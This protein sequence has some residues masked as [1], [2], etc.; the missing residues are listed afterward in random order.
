MAHPYFYH[1]LP[2]H[3]PHS[4]PGVLDVILVV[5]NTKMYESRYRLF[6]KI[7]D[8]V[9]LTPHVRVTVAEM[10]YGERPFVITDKFEKNQVFLR[11]SDELWHKENLINLAIK[12][13][14][15][16]FKYVAWMDA[17]I[18]FTKH[19]SWAKET[20]EAL[21]H[22][23]IVQPWSHAI[24]LGPEDQ[25]I[26]SYHS[27]C[28]CYNTGKKMIPTA[29]YH[30]PKNFFYPHS[31]YIW[32]ARRE[33]FETV[34]QLIDISILGAGDHHM[35]WSLLGRASESFPTTKAAPLINYRKAVY[36][37]QDRAV[38]YVK[39]N[40]GHV[41]GTIYHHWHGKKKDRKYT[42]RWQVLSDFGFDP[43]TD[44]FKDW[45]G[46]WKLRVEDDRQIKL[47]DGIREYMAS[48]NEDSIDLE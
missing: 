25:L 3:N 48:R 37:W 15:E 42:T 44:L 35:A 7:L 43:E 34:G 29:S 23:M 22:Y 30:G 12:T 13:L 20:I 28:W 27:F 16:D 33:F 4:H 32:A 8:E 31:G 46:L 14:P 10:A 5:S 6:K 36:C 17:D 1:H 21:Q 19:K 2:T 47:R 18:S 26:N 11:S 39:K 24:D 41:P 40:I 45:Q 9:K 38:K